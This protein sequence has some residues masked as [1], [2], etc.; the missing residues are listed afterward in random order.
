MILAKRSIKLVYRL[1][2]KLLFFFSF[3]YV[4]INI[5]EFFNTYLIYEMEKI[6]KYL[7][8][9]SENILIKNKNFKKTKDPWISIITP[10]YNK[11][12]TIHRYLRSIQNQL[13]NSIE[14]IFIDDKSNDN[15]I[16]IIE[17]LQKKDERI[18]LIKNKKRKG[19]LISRNRGVL[20]SKGEFLLLVDPDDIISENILKYTYRLAKKYDYDLT[21]YNIYVGNYEL[22]LPEVVG[23]LNDEP[24]FKPYIYLYL[25]YG[26]GKLLQ[27]DYY[28]T[29]KLIKKNLF[30]RALNSINRYYLKQFMVDCE[31][32]MINF[33]LYKLSNSLYFTKRIGYYY[34]KTK[35]SITSGLVD[36]KKRLKSNFL[37]FR[38]IFL[39]T[40]NNSIEK[41]IANYIFHEVNYYHPE[42]INLLK[43]DSKDFKLY[44]NTI[45]LF[46]ENEFIS[47]N[48]KKIL[49]NMRK[50]I[51]NLT[52]SLL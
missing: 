24:I 18:I 2:F 51:N 6:E 20:K 1:L 28:V 29:N 21:R 40:K 16:K 49:K 42:I 19:T 12:K 14:I 11:E 52:I 43:E 5:F 10:V 36:F 4:N 9:C 34:I 44:K 47:L 30:I 39:S 41:I 33:M 8:L 35:K 26:L 22:N 50:A 13:F 27:L 15:S 38:F 23:Y 31:D 37:Y 3:I 48:S 7:K 45:N 17:E 32:G 25:F 46:I